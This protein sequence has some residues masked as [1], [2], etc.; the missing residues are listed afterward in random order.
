MLFF[1]KIFYALYFTIFFPSLNSFKILATSQLI[2][3]HLLFLSSPLKPT[4]QNKKQTKNSKK[5]YQNKMKQKDYTHPRG[6]NTHRVGFVLA[7]CYWAWGLWLIYF[8]RESCFSI[9]QQVSVANKGIESSVTSYC[10]DFVWFD[11][12][13]VSLTSYV[14]WSFCLVSCESSTTSGYSNLPVSSST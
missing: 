1:K 2:Q 8:I 13:Q 12:V 14:H 9:Y 5:K 3:L 6:E 7:H 10:W 4:K 11:L